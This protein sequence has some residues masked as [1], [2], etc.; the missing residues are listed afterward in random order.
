MLKLKADA[1]AHLL[2]GCRTYGLTLGRPGVLG[3]CRGLSE[4]EVRIVNGLLRSPVAQIRMFGVLAVSC[5]RWFAAGLAIS[6]VGCSLRL[7]TVQ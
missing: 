7:G 6:V 5:R 4:T 1:E 2:F 3:R